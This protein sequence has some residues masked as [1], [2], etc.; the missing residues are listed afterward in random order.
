MSVEA[1][2]RPACDTCGQAL[3]LIRPGRTTC[4][5]CVKYGPPRTQAEIDAA[6]PPPPVP[7]PLVPC[8]GCGRTTVDGEQTRLPQADGYCLG[9]RLDGAHT[10]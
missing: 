5:Q 6:T 10:P 9:C 8:R 3:L 7:P 2:M 1:Q 4:A